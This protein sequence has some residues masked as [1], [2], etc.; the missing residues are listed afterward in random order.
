M[1]PFEL[2]RVCMQIGEG[3][4]LHGVDS[5]ESTGERVMKGERRKMIIPKNKQATAMSSA[6][7]GVLNGSS[8]FQLEG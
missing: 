3:S 6:V 2:R 7:T 4:Y 5:G 8:E 1:H